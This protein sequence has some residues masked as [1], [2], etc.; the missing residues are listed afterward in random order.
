MSCFTTDHPLSEPWTFYE[1]RSKDRDFDKRWSDQTL[2]LATVATVE[3]FWQ[4]QGTLTGIA[5]YLPSTLFAHDR[6]GKKAIVRRAEPDGRM[7]A[8][9]VDAIGLF[10]AR[11][12]ADTKATDEVTKKRF[13]QYRRRQDSSQAERCD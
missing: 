12:P 7:R 8:S 9:A 3:E 10:R 6:G 4:I 1:V 2:S 5:D 13:T 11:I